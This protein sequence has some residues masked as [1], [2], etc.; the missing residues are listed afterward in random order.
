MG[1]K[2]HRRICRCGSYFYVT[3]D[4]DTRKLCGLCK[5][6]EK[7]IAKLGIKPGGGSRRLLCSKCH[8]PFV[9]AV[10]DPRE[11][12]TPCTLE[13]ADIKR[14]KNGPSSHNGG[15]PRHIV[16]RHMI[17]SGRMRQSIDERLAEGFKA[18][19]GEVDSHGN[20]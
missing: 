19:E 2:K 10:G 8:R 1:K 9:T 15:N 18:L 16:N 11:L 20:D 17:G 3:A 12:C 14:A 7:R 5:R 13:A 6:L 4:N